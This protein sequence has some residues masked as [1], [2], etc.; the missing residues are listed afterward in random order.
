MNLEALISVTILVSAAFGLGILT[1]LFITSQPQTDS[2]K[3]NE[4]VKRMLDA[5]RS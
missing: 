2:E 3:D 5:A 4:R 1:G